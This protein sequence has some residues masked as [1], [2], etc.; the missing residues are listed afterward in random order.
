MILYQLCHS[1]QAGQSEFNVMPFGSYNAP[2]TFQR[3][4]EPLPAGTP[5]EVC[6]NALLEAKIILFVFWNAWTALKVKCRLCT[7]VFLIRIKGRTAKVK[8]Q[9]KTSRKVDLKWQNMTSI[10]EN[11]EQY[12]RSATRI[13]T[14]SKLSQTER[15]TVLATSQTTRVALAKA[16]KNK[17]DPATDENSVE[18]RNRGL[19]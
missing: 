19:A 15:L 4:M 6:E 12:F 17:A 3:L 9:L 2:S 7:F 13:C 14:R 18:N 1:S 8:F 5:S 10:Q 11:R 16:F